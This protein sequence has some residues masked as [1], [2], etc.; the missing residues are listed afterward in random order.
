MLVGQETIGWI[1]QIHPSVASKWDLSDAVAFEITLADLLAASNVARVRPLRRHVERHGA[2][3][4]SVEHDIPQNVVDLA[5][6]VMKRE[7][8]PRASA[9]AFLDDPPVGIKP[10]TKLW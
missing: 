4:S 5:L 3:L 10:E 1:G 9:P 7:I 6:E 2:L 8:E